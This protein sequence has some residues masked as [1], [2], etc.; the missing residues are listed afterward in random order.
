MPD[1][2]SSLPFERPEELTAALRE[3][4]A[5]PNEAADLLP[6]LGRLHEWPAPQPA[7]EDTRFLVARLAKELRALSPVRQAI[8]EHSQD[9]VAILLA[10]ARAQ[11]SLFR[12]GFWLVSALIT[13]IGAAVVLSRLEVDQ[14]LVLRA[15]GPLLAFLGTLVAFR[16]RAVRTMELELACLPSPLQLTVARLVIVLGYD[17]LLGLALSLVF[18]LGATGQVLE[19][20]LSW[21]M[22]LLLVVGLAFLLSLRLQVTAAA[23]VAYASWLAIL[24]LTATS[25]LQTLLLVPELLA[26]GCI[27][28][29][30][31]IIAL[32]RLR[33]DLPRLLPQH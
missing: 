3:Q 27:G 14:A 25:G 5:T 13:A 4:G 6:A 32:L 33:T 7:S 11:V 8:R 16:G 18:W 29:A 2:Q 1:P 30:L 31:L 12:P 26:L 9:R 20:T 22:P 19:L 15:S 17:V 10:I 21:L 28:V 24:T 23:S